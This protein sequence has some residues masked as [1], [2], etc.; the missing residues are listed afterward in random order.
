M[1]EVSLYIVYV[2]YLGSLSSPIFFLTYNV[3]TLRALLNYFKHVTG[4]FC[5]AILDI[6]VILSVA[7]LFSRDMID[8]ARILKTTM[9]CHLKQHEFSFYH[10]IPYY[11]YML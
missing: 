6:T 11:A 5:F 8:A 10:H 3:A 7:V 4:I 1:D 2:N 9:K